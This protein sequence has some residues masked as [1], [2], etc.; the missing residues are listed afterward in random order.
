MSHEEDVLTNQEVH[1][2]VQ[3]LEE[4]EPIEEDDNDSQGDDDH[5]EV[6]LS[7]NSWT[8]FDTHQD[9]IFTIF[10]HPQLPLVAT[11][12][13][14][15][16]AYIWTTHSQP[17]KIVSELKGHSES[18]ISGGFTS[19]GKFCITGDMT[20]KIMI[21]RAVNR[22]QKWNVVGELQEVEEISWIKVHPV[23]NCFAFGSTDGSVWAYQI[24][25]TLE[26]LMSGFSHSLDCTAGA[27]YDVT[28][29]ETLKLLTVSEDGSM[30]AWN[31]F[32][33]QQLYRVDQHSQLKGLSPPWVTVARDFSNSCGIAAIGSRDA[34]LCILNLES[35]HVLTI[36]KTL[37]L[38][39]NQDV[40]EASIEALAWCGVQNILASGMVSGDLVLFDTNTWRPRRSI[41]MPDAIT[42][43]EFVQDSHVLM[44]SCMDGK[45][46]VIDSR[47]GDH[48]Y[49]AHGHNMGV[50][51]FVVQDQGKKIITAGDEGVSLVFQ[52]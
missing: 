43:L 7:N 41:R 28:D 8:Y 22:G 30:V 20:G 11:G 38:D 32:T 6:D 17:P 12:G 3:D 49:V 2:E 44:A 16:T 23:H 19:D 10:S 33:G 26:Q 42:K 18:V 25:P 36:L 31:C 34:Q 48:L 15:N 24:D 46:Y 35:G 39:Q 50:L 45:V 40:F 27:F 21:H 9:S 14:D 47:T 13:G 5:I 37:E 51:D 52:L 29:K 1:E 4:A